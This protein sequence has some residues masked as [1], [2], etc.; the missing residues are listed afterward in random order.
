MPRITKIYTRKGDDGTTSL[1]SRERVPKDALRVQA[2]GTVDELNSTIGVAIASGL[3]DRLAAILPVIQNELFH[4]GSDLS[5]YKEDKEKYGIPQINSRHVAKLESLIDELSEV[6]GPLQNFILPGGSI[7]AAHL[8]VARTVCR[9]AER[10]AITLA[11]EEG[12]EFN[13]N[14]LRYLNRLS[15][16]LFVMARYENHQKGVA[17]PL[18]DKLA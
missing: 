16:A 14:V 15:D 4:L 12:G 7:G 6:V 1:G 13:A 2:Y 11:R 5:F 18:W 10:K 17:E 8:Q 9:R 3:C